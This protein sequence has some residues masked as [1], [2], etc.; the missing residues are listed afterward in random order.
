[1]NR[2]QSVTVQSG[3]S[4]VAIISSALILSAG[5]SG[6]VVPLLCKLLEYCA[7]STR[8][9]SICL[10]LWRFGFV[11]SLELFPI[12]SYSNPH[13]LSLFMRLRNISCD[14]MTSSSCSSSLAR[15]Y[16]RLVRCLSQPT[17]WMTSPLCTL[18]QACNTHLPLL[19]CTC[20][21]SCLRSCLTHRTCI[22]SSYISPYPSPPRQRDRSK[23]GPKER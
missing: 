10:F 16:T 7:C 22:R 18:S 2:K 20:L 5:T 17:R 21:S 13:P 15:G 9:S 19:N 4:F 11:A 8:N 23:E 12:A 1:M 14:R 3:R 6:L